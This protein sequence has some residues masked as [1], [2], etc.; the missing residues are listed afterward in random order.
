VGAA[1]QAIET[2]NP[3]Q[4]SDSVNTVPNPVQWVDLACSICKTVIAT[5]SAPLPD[6]PVKCQT[7]RRDPGC[8]SWCP[9]GDGHHDELLEDDKMCY[10][11]EQ[12]VPL[13]TEP[14]PGLGAVASA[15]V[16]PLRRPGGRDSVVVQANLRYGNLDFDATPS[17]A[18]QI[19]ALL[20]EVAE[21]VD[22]EKATVAGFAEEVRA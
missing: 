19:A 1:F 17:E 13:T 21:R 16:Y 10:G 20:I 22:A 9:Q 12:S 18:R 8:A 2:T 4:G 6:V 3:N 11:D 7:C 15:E 5:V 14:S